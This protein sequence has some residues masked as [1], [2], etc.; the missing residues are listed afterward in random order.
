MSATRNAFKKVKEEVSIQEVARMHGLRLCWEGKELKSL[1]PFHKET[2]PS[3]GISLKKGLYHCFSCGSGGDAITLHQKLGNFA[4]PWEAMIDLSIRYGVELPK[5]PP[6]WFSWQ[7][8][9][10]RRRK[11]LVEAVAESYRRRFFRFFKEDFERI[12]DPAERKEEAS[13]VWEELWPLA[14]ACALWRVNT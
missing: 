6:E 4:E 5:R 7:D 12:S 14:W 10:A 3:F 1:C 9:K 8:E 11:M 2:T 13:K